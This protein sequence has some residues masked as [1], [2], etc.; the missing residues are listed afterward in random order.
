MR[1]RRRREWFTGA[2]PDRSELYLF[3]EMIRSP[4]DPER[5]PRGTHGP[6]AYARWRRDLKGHP[7]I[8]GSKL[9]QLLMDGKPRTL[10]AIG[11]E[12]VDFTAD[13]VS[14]TA[15]GEALWALVE[16]GEVEHTG[17]A[18]ILFR[19]AGKALRAPDFEAAARRVE[20]EDEP[21]DDEQQEEHPR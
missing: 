20:G 12:L 13:I 18:P 21:L 14:G 4:Y 2:L 16:A 6:G 11:I 7:S 17:E 15:L 1:T 8:W 9:A 19:W 3:T 10:N 5:S